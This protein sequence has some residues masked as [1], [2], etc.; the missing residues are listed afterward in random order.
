MLLRVE[1]GLLA[2]LAS[3]ASVWA[4]VG[5]VLEDLAIGGR[6]LNGRGRGVM[7][8]RWMG[9]TVRPEVLAGGG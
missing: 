1:A 6:A 3:L 5:K 7:R 8:F 2:W 4:T 9:F